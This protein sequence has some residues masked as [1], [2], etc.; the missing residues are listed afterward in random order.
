MRFSGLGSGSAAEGLVVAGGVEDEVAEQFA[1]G[2][3]DDAEVAVGDEHDDAGSGVFMAEADV[4]EAAVVAEGDPCPVLS[5]RS[6]RT[7]QWVSVRWPGVALGRAGRRRRGW[8]AQVGSGEGAGG[9]RA[10][11][12]GRKVP[13]LGR[14]WWAGRV[15]RAA[16]S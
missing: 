10:R 3:V 1:G 12:T 4:V 9:C 14:W 11:R 8:C 13:E 2:G 5:T 15:G 16:R 7:R 6:L